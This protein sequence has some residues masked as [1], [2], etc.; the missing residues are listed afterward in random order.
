MVIVLLKNA[1]KDGYYYSGFVMQHYCVLSDDQA[2]LVGMWDSHE[3][4][5]WFWEYENNKKIKRKLLYMKDIDKMDE[6]SAGFLPIKEVIPKA[7][8]VI[9]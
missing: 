1:L 3:E 6:I 4:C 7:E 5:F 9:E 2:K 8:F